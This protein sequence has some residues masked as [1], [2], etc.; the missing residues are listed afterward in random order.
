MAAGRRVGAPRARRPRS[1]VWLAGIL[2]VTACTTSP[3]GRTQLRLFP[4]SEMAAMGVAAYGKMQAELAP[5]TDAA[6]NATVGC[7][8]RG[9]VDVLPEPER[10]YAWEVTV[11]QDPSAN[12]FALPGAKIGVHTG[13][14]EVARNQHQL[15]AVIGH[16]VAHVIA[17]HANERMSTAFA[18]QTG[19][20]LV[21]VIAG[22]SSPAQRQTLALLGLGAQVG[23]L[24]PFSRT[25]E[26]EADLIGQDLMARA[27][28]DPRESVTLWQN[29]DRAGGARPPAFLSTHP[30]SASRMQELQARMPQALELYEASRAQGRRPRCA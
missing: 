11:F 24:L 12:A 7:V 20:Q 26:R 23:I 22:A 19:L 17:G 6:V 15:A 1:G 30:S 21:E 9:V 28:F 14:L 3:L 18:T 5:S 4:E 25:Q 29:M 16:E 10:R 2:W 13:L 27:G 8:V